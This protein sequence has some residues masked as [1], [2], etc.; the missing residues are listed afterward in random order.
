MVMPSVLK[1]DSPRRS[2]QEGPGRKC[3]R[4]YPKSE[5]HY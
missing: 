4:G 1:E 2:V 5:A 3:V